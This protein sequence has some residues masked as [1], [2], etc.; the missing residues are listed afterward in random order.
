MGE[1]KAVLR[2]LFMMINTYTEKADLKTNKQTTYFLPQGIRKQ[3]QGELEV[4][5]RKNKDQNRINKI[6]NRKTR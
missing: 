1:T 2:G 6:E 4:R 5:K 3:E